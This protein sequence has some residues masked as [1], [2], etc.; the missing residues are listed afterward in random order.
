MNECF[1]QVTAIE[2]TS[3]AYK[4]IHRRFSLDGGKFIA[5]FLQNASKLFIVDTHLCIGVKGCL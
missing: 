4:C 1:F 3:A 5:L 2:D